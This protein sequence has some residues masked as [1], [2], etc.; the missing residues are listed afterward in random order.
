MEALPAELIKLY[1]PCKVLPYD[2]FHF[3][4]YRWFEEIPVDS[5]EPIHLICLKHTKS[6]WK[7]CQQ[8]SLRSHLYPNLTSFVLLCKILTNFSCGPTQC[9]EFW[10]FSSTLICRLQ[11]VSSASFYVITMLIDKVF[12]IRN[13][14]KL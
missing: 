4:A 3:F 7:L 6:A 2:I 13:F 8:V 1:F 14:Y 5:C 10:I 12:I 11:W 9:T